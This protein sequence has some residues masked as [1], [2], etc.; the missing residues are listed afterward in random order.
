MSGLVDSI[1]VMRLVAFIEEESGVKVPPEDVV[2]E[3]FENIFAIAN[4]AE[5]MAC[6]KNRVHGSEAV[7]V[8]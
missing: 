2:I 5:K 7:D 6:E 3:H 4:Y 8:N 1:G